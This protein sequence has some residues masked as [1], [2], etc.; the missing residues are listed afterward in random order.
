MIDLNFWQGK[1]VFITGHTGFKGSWLSLWLHSLGAQVQGYALNAPTTPS[2][3]AEI[4]LQNK[5]ASKIADIR[6]L[7][8]LYQCMNAFKPEIVFHLAAQPLVRLS[9]EIPVDTYSTNVMG[10]VHLLESTRS[11]NTVKA[12]VNVTSD[13]CYENQEWPWGYRESEPMG[14]FD[15]YSS[16]KGCAELVT[17]SYRRSFFN[18]HNYHEHGCAIASARAGNVI[19]GGDWA[20]DRLVPDILKAFADK[21]EVYIRNPQAI[22][23]WQHVLEPLSGYIKLAESLYKEGVSFAEAWNFGP[24]ENNAKPVEWI[25][26]QMAEI[27][28]AGASFAVD[29]S[30]HVHEAHFLKLDCSKAKL[31]LHWQP[32]W[33]L[34]ESLD[35]TVN[36]YKAWLEGINMYDYTINEINDYMNSQI[37]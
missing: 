33:M 35:R 31:K 10:T 30:L 23:P 34:L 2:L 25:V 36:W 28:G 18:E 32:Q 14:G 24:M 5:I 22:R 7:N 15:P 27:W 4:Q 26:K 9:Y 37:G 13:K 1:R 17:N 21:K 8:T 19:G 12:L 29:K 20:Q 3:F 11:I 6:D 16:S